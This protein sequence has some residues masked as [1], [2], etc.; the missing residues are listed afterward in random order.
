[1][2]P[3]VPLVQRP[4][5]DYLVIVVGVSQNDDLSSRRTDPTRLTSALS[6]S[7]R[8]TRSTL[9]RFRATL[10]RSRRASDAWRTDCVSASSSPSGR[11]CSSWRTGSTGSPSP[12]Y[13]SEWGSPRPVHLRGPDDPP[14]LIQ[15]AA[16]SCRFSCRPAV[17]VGSELAPGPFWEV[18]VQKTCPFCRK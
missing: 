2:G 10:R 12:T 16:P 14:A 8:S 13:L 6:T 3:I 7:T 4:P 1:M 5:G 9:P 11:A 17:S 15:R 18:N